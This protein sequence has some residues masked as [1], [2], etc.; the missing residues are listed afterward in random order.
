VT[1]SRQLLGGNPRATALR[2]DLREPDD[3]LAQLRGE[4]A[5]G[6]IDL[7]RPVAVLLVSVLHFVPGEEAYPYVAR[8]LEAA[9]PG[10]WLAVSHSSVEGFASLEKDDFDSAEQAYRKTTTPVGLRTRAEIRRF[11]DGLTLAD[12]G[13]VWVPEWR[14]DE[15]GGPFAGEPRRSG[16][17][18]AL[19]HKGQ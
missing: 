19:G 13:L 4:P 5:A 18:A 1:H 3:L 9:A 8:L 6:V 17:L 10:S 11:F 12:P 15:T 14:P 2:A 7:E 16:M